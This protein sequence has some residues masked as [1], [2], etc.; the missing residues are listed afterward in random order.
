[1]CAK[2]NRPHVR[3]R[4]RSPVTSEPIPSGLTHE[5]GPGHARNTTSELFLLAVAN[6]VGEQT[7]YESAGTRDAR[8]RHLVHEVAVTDPQWLLGMIGWLRGEG[9]MRSASLVAA[10][11]GAKARL[12]A[13]AHGHSR[14]FVDAALARADEPGETLA[15][16]TSRYGRRVPKPVKRG[17]ADAVQRLYTEH[18][19]LKYDTASAGF[20]FSDVLNLVHA[21][22][23]A[24]KPWQGSLFEHVHER[25]HQRGTPPDQERLPMLAANAHLVEAARDEPT[26]LLDQARLKRAGITWETAL[27]LAGDRVD[28]ATLWE[29]LIPSL[30][31]MALLRN[32]RN[33]DEAGVSDAVAEQVA[34]R[35]SDPEQV[36]RSRQLPMRFLS[37]YRAAPSLRW[38]HALEKALQASLGN[39]PTLAGRTLVLVDRSGS[40][41]S[42]LSARSGLNRADAAAIFGAAL[43]LR[44]ERADLVEFGTGSVPVQVHR[45]DALLRV[46]E[47]F[48]WLGGTDTTA[49]V[50]G[51]YRGH[52]RVVIV[53]D[54][55]AHQHWG[56]NPTEQVP[57]SVPVYTWNL[58]GY[59][60]GHAPSGEGNRHTFGGF[61]DAAFRMV[62][63]LEAGRDAR[64]PWL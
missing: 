31:Y 24:D 42:R 27:S 49:A 62:P 55:Q 10:L 7:F 43:T 35:L 37:A 45:G 9:N 33:F 58:A 2:F 25:R 39:V 63:L 20:R 57:D 5:H 48:H 28:K 26:L 23:S 59:K 30:G 44:C 47:R 15:Y 14:A 50:R 21:S 38:A 16:W 6:M 17:I 46:I 19:V 11:E 12:D 36:A 54:E 41:Q 52:D 13:G 32:L 51:H 8:F 61:G 53:T 64:W 34:A 56:G 4:G 60:Y 18:A 29:S 1:M 22:P 40:M 3:P